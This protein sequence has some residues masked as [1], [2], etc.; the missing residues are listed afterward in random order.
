MKKN[1]IFIII[2]LIVA[3]VTII[4]VMKPFKTSNKKNPEYVFFYAENQ[5]AD[6]PTTLGA[7]YF[8]KLVDERTDGRIR[9]IIKSDAQLGNESQVL[10]QIQYGGIAFARISL[11][12]IAELI[13]EMNV[14]Q[15]PYLYSDSDHMWRV[16]DGE[17]GEE[18]LSKV[19]Q[20]DYVG[21][22]W[23]DAGARNFYSTQKPITTLEDLQNMNIRV[24]ESDMMADMVTALGANA[25]KTPYADVYSA[26]QQRIVD[27]AENNWPSYEAMKHYRVAG[28]YTVD[29]H[30][31]VPEM[32]ICSKYIWEQLSDE[33]R[34]IIQECA[35]ESA[36]YE[37]QLWKEREEKSRQIALDYGIELIELSS[38]EKL[39]FRNAMVDVY[40]KYCKDQLDTI[41]R[42][43]QE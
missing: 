7:E 24:Q 34:K 35:T 21:L 13:P 3:V 11:S 15:L 25:V 9:I 38:D 5:T 4:V 10:K 18:F 42:I 37:R 1:K 39:R 12:Q 43:M 2:T 22:S 32:Q 23:Y 27:G 28:Y 29:E 26:L 19:E 30:T 31:R 40:Y 41:E 36:L 6:Y 33:D 20:C 8:A 17:I 16:L 14:L